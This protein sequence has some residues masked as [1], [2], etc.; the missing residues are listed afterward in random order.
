[1]DGE[2]FMAAS[3]FSGPWSRK[4][5]GGEFWN[6]IALVTAQF[7]GWSP[8]NRK[9]WKVKRGKERNAARFQESGKNPG[10]A[11]SKFEGLM[12]FRCAQRLLY[13]QRSIKHSLSE[14]SKQRLEF[15]DFKFTTSVIAEVFISPSLVL[16]LLCFLH[17]QSSL[18]CFKT[19]F[20]VWAPYFSVV[21]ILSLWESWRWVWGGG[22]SPYFLFRPWELG[23]GR[24]EVISRS[25]CK[26]ETPKRGDAGVLWFPSATCTVWQLWPTCFHYQTVSATFITS[27]WI[28][29]N[30]LCK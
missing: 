7:K 24:E 11:C 16:L 15:T 9:K 1:M 20:Q 10:T 26:V 8:W 4:A 28:D 27:Y 25:S 29:S 19:I 5:S 14:V 17:P 2:R 22:C 21:L 18:Y 13:F 3:G 30:M 23:L 12:V 6:S